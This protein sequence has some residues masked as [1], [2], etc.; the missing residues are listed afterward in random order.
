MGTGNSLRC[1][2]RLLHDS[3]DIVLVNPSVIYGID[4]NKAYRYHRERRNLV[5]VI[6]PNSKIKNKFR[7]LERPELLDYILEFNPYD[8]KYESYSVPILLINKTILIFVGPKK[9][10]DFKENILLPLLKSSTRFVTG[11]ETPGIS[12]SIFDFNDLEH[13][14]RLASRKEVGAKVPTEQIWSFDFKELR[15]MPKEVATIKKGNK[16]KS[17]ASRD[18]LVGSHITHSESIDKDKAYHYS[19]SKLHIVAKRASDIILSM[20]ALILLSPLFCIIYLIVKI[21]S[22]ESALYIH[23]RLGHKGKKLKLIKFRTMAT[24]SSK[25]FRNEEEKRDF[26][27]QFKLE[28]D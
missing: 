24:G 10:L 2:A 9:Y 19:T 12:K 11:V 6:K 16:G 18:I 5:T 26:Y 25:S 13:L 7:I 1:F 3:E 4:I 28:D 8:G 27:R 17:K 20:A 22:S 23:E 21:D 15:R 14:N